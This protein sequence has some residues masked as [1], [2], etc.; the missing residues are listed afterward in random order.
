MAAAQL[1]ALKQEPQDLST[2]AGPSTDHLALEQ[3][4]LALCSEYPKGITDEILMTDQPNISAEL[5]MK[6]LQRLLS[7]VPTN[8]A[9]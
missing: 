5:R 3:R 7:Q 8:T 9:V 4:I 6:A 2:P 1:A